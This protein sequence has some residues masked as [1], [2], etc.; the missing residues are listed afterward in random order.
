MKNL[1]IFLFLSFALNLNSRPLTIINKT[2]VPLDVIIW[3]DSKVI[4][5]H[6]MNS[7]DEITIEDIGFGLLMQF[8]VS[9]YDLVA[10]GS[11]YNCKHIRHLPNGYDEVEL[12]DRHFNQHLYWFQPRI[13]TYSI[14][15]QCQIIQDKA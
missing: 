6:I 7:S 3:K 9:G 1:I 10:L 15:F 4:Y 5:H 13:S 8:K 12:D 14:D 11:G 2:N